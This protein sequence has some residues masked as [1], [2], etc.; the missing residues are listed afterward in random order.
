MCL[1]AGEPIAGPLAV[2]AGPPQ[3]LV[4]ID[5]ADSTDQRLVKERPLDTGT[6]AA[7]RDE[8]PAHFFAG[9]SLGV[10]QPAGDF[11][12][13]IENGFGLAGHLLYRP[14][15][16][17]IFGLRL[18]VCR[19]CRGVWFDHQELAEISRAVAARA[20]GGLAGLHLGIH[21]VE[22]N[23]FEARRRGDVVDVDP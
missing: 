14:D 23:P 12:D 4:G 8:R 9:G 16:N 11:A 10:A 15:S 6:S 17:G 19:E 20:G 3:R 7:Q 21:R 18:D 2:D 22:G 5:V 1:S 13:H